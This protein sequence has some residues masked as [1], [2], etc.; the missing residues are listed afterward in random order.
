MELIFYKYQGTGN[1]FIMIN[2]FDDDEFDLSTDQIEALCDRRF[3]IG[4]DGLIILRKDPEHDFKM[5]YYNSDGRQSSMC[6]NGGRC[7]VQFAIDLGFIDN[8]CSFSAIDGIHFANAIDGN[9]RLSMND[10]QTVDSIGEAY[11]LDTG[12][13]HYVIER[14]DE[15]SAKDFKSLASKIRYSEDFKQNGINVNTYCERSVNHIIGLTYERGVEDITWSCGT[16]VVAM[17][18]SYIKSHKSNGEH[19]VTVDNLGGKL[20][21]EFK[22]DDNV[23]SEIYLIGPAEYVFKG[24]F[25]L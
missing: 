25:S 6:G 15:I 3:G 11:V 2:Q 16:G 9:I 18:I 12:S 17:A 10:V 4:G 21:A 14:D 1:D 23:F 5:V 24:S 7:I 13:P 19:K 8:K 20:E 22:Y